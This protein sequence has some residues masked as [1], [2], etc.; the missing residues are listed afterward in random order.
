MLAGGGGAERG[1]Q[2]LRE[3]AEAW[4]G[5]VKAPSMGTAPGRE[6]A[7]WVQVQA[8][9]GVTRTGPRAG[10]RISPP[11]TSGGG[12]AGAWRAPETLAQL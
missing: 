4:P 8:S 5:Q 2:G 12:S 3:V 11:G 1:G 10:P 9:G 7:E 6:E